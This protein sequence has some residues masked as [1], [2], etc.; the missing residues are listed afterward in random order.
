M[1]CAAG[2]VNLDTDVLV[3]VLVR[4]ASYSCTALY[5]ARCPALTCCAPQRLCCGRVQVSPAA[6]MAI[7]CIKLPLNVLCS[8]RLGIAGGSLGAALIIGLRTE[9]LGLLTNTAFHVYLRLRYQEQAAPAPAAVPVSSSARERVAAPG[10]QMAGGSA[11][12]SVQAAAGGAGGSRGAG[13]MRRTAG[14]AS[15][16][17][18]GARAADGGW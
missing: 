13:L 7:A 4:G 11:G 2:A 3:L 16:L 14:A 12:G 18:N 1:D 17:A 15:R 9:V 10:G 8:L 6:A 5:A